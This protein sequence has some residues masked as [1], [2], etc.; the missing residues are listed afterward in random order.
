MLL[1]RF[2]TAIVFVS[3]LASP[4]LAQRD[5]LPIAS[6]NEFLRSTTSVTGLQAG[7]AVYVKT[8]GDPDARQKLVYDYPEFEEANALAVAGELNYNMM[9]RYNRETAT[10]EALIDGKLLALKAQDFLEVKIGDRIYRPL[11][12]LS[13]G[14][15]THDFAELQSASADEVHLVV[16]RFQVYQASNSTENRGIVTPAGGEKY[17]IDSTSYLIGFR[18]VPI[19]VPRRAKLLIGDLNVC[20]AK[21]LDQAGKFR[22]NE[23][24][25]MMTFIGLVEKCQ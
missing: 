24:A 4:V 18:P 2:S 7:G 25:F 16:K 5:E 20:Q 19:E 21:A 17:K 1:I 6:L 9:A 23:D 10:I 15:V 14:V 22:R 8:P 11:D 12:Q 13:K 3:V